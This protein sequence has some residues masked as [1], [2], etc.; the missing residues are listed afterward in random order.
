[1]S[2]GRVLIALAAAMLAWTSASPAAAQADARDGSFLGAYAIL[3]RDASTGQTGVAIASSSFSAGSGLPWLDRDAGAVAVLAGEPTA[4]GR[5]ALEALRSGRPADAALSAAGSAPGSPGGAPTAVLD[6]QCGRAST[7]GSGA[8]RW[9][10]TERGSVG[11]ICWVAVGSLLPGPAFLSRAVAAFADSSGGLVDRMHA[12]LRAADRAAGDVAL[13]RSAAIWIDAPDAASGALGRARLRLQVEDVQRPAD[14][15]D[16]LLRAGRADAL[17]RRAGAAVDAG[18]HGRAIDL[19]DRALEIDPATAAAWLARGRALL[20]RG[21]E[22]E[23]ETAFQ[24]MLEVNP[25]LL[26]LLGDPATDAEDRAPTVRQGMIPYRPRLLR[27]LDVYRRAF[28]RG[29]VEFGGDGP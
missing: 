14:A 28:F 26:H 2:A 7:A 3:A 29:D 6:G 22:A 13:T 21:S 17:A 25:Y 19:A 12:F 24:R 27:R 9:S 15:L 8:Y 18:D 16:V 11:G 1:M 10:G 5:A 23:A 4:A 20:Y